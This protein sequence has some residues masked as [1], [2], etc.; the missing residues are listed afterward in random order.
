[1]RQLLASKRKSLNLSQRKLGEL[2]GLSQQAVSDIEQ[3]L[4]Q[5][6]VGTWD[7]LEAVL[8]TPAKKLRDNTPM[9]TLSPPKGE[10]ND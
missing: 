3:G 2:I 8:K 4:R 6:K 7:K 1:M 5:G 10:N 9:A